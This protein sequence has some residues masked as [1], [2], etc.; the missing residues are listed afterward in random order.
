MEHT[1]KKHVHIAKKVFDENN[2]DK[3][4]HALDKKMEKIMK[5]WRVEKFCQNKI[6][7]DILYSKVI[8]DINHKIAPYLKTIFII[9]GWIALVSGLIGIFLFLIR[10]SALGFAFSFWFGIWIRIL[11]YLLIALAFD[12]FS[13]LVGIG[14][15]RMKRR[16]PSIALVSFFVSIIFFIIA[17]IPS[18]FYASVRYGSFWSGLLNLIISAVILI[19]ILR[20]KEM[21]T[22]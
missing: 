15:I 20:N 13:V 7:H 9:L 22:K 14:L 8:T 18:G 12:L 16:L 6:V 1:E 10:L 2:M 11:L 5:K 3:A 17:L 19:V 4:E 21:F